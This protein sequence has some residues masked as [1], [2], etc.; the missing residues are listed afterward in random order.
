[1]GHFQFLKQKKFY[2]NLLIIL[3]LCI[4]LFWLAFILLDKYT[5]HDKVYNMPNLIGRNYKEVQKEYSRDFHFILID[6]VY[7]KGQEPGSI[8]QQDP[9]PDS[10]VK[11]GRNVYYIIVAENPEQVEMPNLKNL[12]LRQAI[13][14]LESKGLEIEWLQF[15]NYFAKNAII[16]QLYQGSS[17]EPG[18]IIN[19]GSGIVLRV[20]KG[21]KAKN[22]AIPNLIGK[23]ESDAKRLLHMAGLNLKEQFFE[24]SDSL[25]YQCI[26]KMMPGPSSPAVPAGTEITLWFRSN[27]KFNFD[28]QM[29]ELLKEDSILNRPVIVDTLFGNDTIVNDPIETTDYEYEDDF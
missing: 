25:E 22:I 21:D 13:G 9:L 20:G 2:V 17:I 3:L 7:P 16:D 29:N 28:K 19:K 26:S 14:T 10:K 15:E 27:R 18:T 8:I 12:S 1:M 23:P 11:K 4:V 6:S 24:D 5:R